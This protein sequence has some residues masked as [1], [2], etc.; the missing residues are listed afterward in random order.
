M[1]AKIIL[2]LIRV[3]EGRQVVV[4][5]KG[6]AQLVFLRSA[7]LCLAQNSLLGEKVADVQPLSSG[8]CL[9]EASLAPSMVSWLMILADF[10]CVGVFGLLQIQSVL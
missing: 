3:G 7:I 9:L 10:H 6:S 4:Q 8:S 1:A 2:L 5:W